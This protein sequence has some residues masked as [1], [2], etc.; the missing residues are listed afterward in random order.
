MAVRTVA[1]G[2]PAAKY[3][4]IGLCAILLSACASTQR[5]AN[6]DGDKNY[7]DSIGAFANPASEAGL[8]PIASAAFWG[9]RYDRE[10]QDVDVAVKFSAALRKI[11]SN[12]E[13]I[14]VMTKASAAAPDSPNVSLEYGKA[15]IEDGRAFEA[16]RHLEK[17]VAAK[18]GDWR[19]ISAYGVALDQI[20]EHKLARQ[21]YDRALTIA[22]GAITVLNNK[23]LSYALSGDLGLAAQTLRA[24]ASGQGSNARVRQNYALVLALKGD[25]KEAERLARSDLP[26]QVADNNIAYFRSLM[27]QPAYWQDLADAGFKSDTPAFESSPSAPA[28]SIKPDAP[29]QKLLEEPKPEKEESD[30]APIALTSP[31]PVVPASLPDIESEEDDSQ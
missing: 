13:A 23:G 26:P 17:A 12:D 29:E 15:L 19:A 14:S 8:D 21:E 16:V 7:R 2:A 22:P 27:N 28:P 24:A 11:G 30:G 10:P 4:G 18:S 1:P 5:S 3:V 25:L 20:G 6:A 31:A 9:T